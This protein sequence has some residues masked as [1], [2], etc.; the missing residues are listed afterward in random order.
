MRATGPRQTACVHLCVRAQQACRSTRPHLLVLT[1]D[2]EVRGGQAGRQR[3]HRALQRKP[4][5]AATTGSVA[6]RC[7]GSRGGGGGSSSGR[8]GADARAHRPGLA[9]KRARAGLGGGGHHSACWAGLLLPWQQ[10]LRGTAHMQRCTMSPRTVAP[11]KAA[12]EPNVQGQNGPGGHTPPC[13]PPPAHPATPAPPHLQ[14]GQGPQVLDVQCRPAP[15]ATPPHC[16]ARQPPER[17]RHAL[18]RGVR[19]R[20]VPPAA[21]AAALL[22]AYGSPP[23]PCRACRGVAVRRSERGCCPGGARGAWA[24]GEGVQVEDDGGGG[25]GGHSSGGC[26]SGS[27][28]G[29]GRGGGRCAGCARRTGAQ[30]HRHLRA[31]Q[32]AQGP[33]CGG[34]RTQSM[35][36]R[37]TAGRPPYQGASRQWCAR[38]HVCTRCTC[39]HMHMRACTRRT[40]TVLRPRP[41]F[42][43]PPPLTPHPCGPTSAPRARPH[44]A[45]RHRA[46]EARRWATRLQAAPASAALAGP[47]APGGRAR[48]T[49]PPVHAHEGGAA[50]WARGP[51]R[52]CMHMRVAHGH[53]QALAAGTLAGRC[54]AR[55]ACRQQ[56]AQRV[57]DCLAIH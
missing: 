47:A 17:W 46:A 1:D 7:G 24:G 28:R 30:V 54:C 41:C 31:H 44:A 8:R 6:P 16:H 48:A 19:T 56:H 25:S 27:G 38:A 53:M 51:R 43:P 45:T 29:G 55:G 15:P 4:L 13:L 26:G 18:R 40:G 52:V 12:R 33:A 3:P 42:R 2:R 20:A 49:R 50:T 21:R 9:H 10:Q 23:S 39:T 11:S 36:C 57:Q 5:L 32:R 14:C 34:P 35:L 37:R 22:R